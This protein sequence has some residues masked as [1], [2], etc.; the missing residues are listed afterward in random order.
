VIY[1]GR[2]K[3]DISIIKENGRVIIKM[4][5]ENENDTSILQSIIKGGQWHC[6][7]EG[8]LNGHM[9]PSFVR[10]ELK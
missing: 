5:S 9:N 7:H 10:L 3:M 1:G 2:Y 6:S 8:T 4:K